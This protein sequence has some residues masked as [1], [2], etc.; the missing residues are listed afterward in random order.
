[1]DQKEFMR[2]VYSKY[3]MTAR[4]QKYGFLDYDRHLCDLITSSVKGESRL[5]EVGIGTGYP[6][7]DFLQKAG[8]EIHG[9]DIAPSLIER[10]KELNPAIHAS[11]GDA[12]NLDF[13]DN[14][15]DATYCF[16]S[17][18]VIPN[19]KQAISEMVRVTK[20]SG[21]LC[22]DAQN[23]A[24]PAI[25]EE[26]AKRVAALRPSIGARLELYARN[27]AKVVLRRGNPNWHAVNYEVPL[28]VG[29]VLD[30]LAALGL[31]DL[32]VFGRH[33]EDQSLEEL[34]G[35]G[36]FPSFQ[37]LVIACRRSAR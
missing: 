16:H 14:E 28:S 29:E 20:L 32:R 13:A 18:W 7:A 8:Y 23:S 27:V 26:F 5:L 30:H 24:H 11:V 17:L 35:T 22:F 37:R 1:M 9:I 19:V 25:A 36:D 12:E 15:F 10:C 21:F 3:W 31:E 34:S 33:E 2:D 4:E 6:V